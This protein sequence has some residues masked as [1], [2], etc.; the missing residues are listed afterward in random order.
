MASPALDREQ[1][2]RNGLLEFVKRS[3]HLVESCEF[4]LEP[5]IEVIC[6]HL[7]ACAY[8]GT[9]S[10][11]L[12]WETQ[13]WSHWVWKGTDAPGGISDLVIAIP[14][15]FSKS[16]TAMVFFPAWVWSWCPEAKF[17]TTSYGEDLALRD[18][19][20]SFDLINNEWYQ[21]RFSTPTEWSQVEV[22]IEG[23]ERASMGYYV[24]TR[25]GSRFST[26]MG[27]RPTGRHAHFLLSDDPIKPDDLKLGGDSA[28]EALAKTHYRW[29][30]IFSNRSA[31][32]ATFCR[33]VIAQRLHMDDLSGHCIEQGAQ[34]L[35]LPMEFEAHEAYESPWGSDWRSKDGEL[36]APK[37]FPQH[38]ISFRKSITPAR[39]W[40]AQYQQ[41]PSP[42]DGSIFQRAWFD[43]RY[44]GTFAKGARLSLSIDSSLKEGAD[45]DFTVIQC[46]AQESMA[47]YLLLDQV[48]LRMGFTDQVAAIQVMFAKHA[49][50]RQLLIEDKANGTAIIDTLKRMLPGVKGV[51][52]RGGKMARAAAVS[53]LWA[54]GN[55]WLPE[56]AP[57][58]AGFVEEHITFPASKNDDQVDCATQYLMEASGKYRAGRNKQAAQ[59]MRNMLR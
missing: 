49:G 32:A 20:R 35:R 40:A 28:R 13:A 7:E 52:P 34:H 5:H 38:V 2:R 47:R 9:Q 29:D 36:L 25:K 42:E 10:F 18:A 46:W 55:V 44:P 50:I 41:R 1:I 58:V 54:A 27:G 11:R 53:P 24:N 21:E 17:I 45:K 6:R 22:H 26:P 37:R 31:D 16:L 3:W 39:D 57:W 14:P 48:R 30:A 15:G 19:K 43:Y 51:D 33:I 23:G 8:Y 12:D 59:A 56:R 4:V